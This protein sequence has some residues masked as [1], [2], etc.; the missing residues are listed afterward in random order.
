MIH[1]NVSIRLV[2][3]Q[4]FPVNSTERCIVFERPPYFQFQSGDWIDLSFPGMVLK[5]GITYSLSSS[6]GEDDLMITF[7]DGLSEFKNKLKGL[8]PGDIVKIIQYGNDYHFTTDAHTSST[9]IAGGV[10]I[11]PFRSMIKEMV[12][13]HA[14]NKV[15]LFYLNKTENFLFKEELEQWKAFLPNLSIVYIVTKEVQ[16]KERER[17][18][19]SNIGKNGDDAFYVAGPE[20]MVESTEHLLVNAG[21]SRKSIKIDSFAG[22]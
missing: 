8:R 10:G 17:I 3:K 9:F 13:T 2:V 16:R 22:Y 5:G 11:A 19:L 1:K 12:D 20:G 14:K 18:L 7:K 15:T 4:N 6:P 21:I